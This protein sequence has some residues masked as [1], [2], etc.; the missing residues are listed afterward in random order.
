MREPI[1][2]VL[3][4]VVILGCEPRASP[5]A[6]PPG[7]ASSES[8]PVP[9]PPPAP[10]AGRPLSREEIVGAWNLT[11]TANYSSCPHMAVGDVRAVQWTI[12]FSLGAFRAR[13]LGGDDMDEHVGTVTA[14][15][16]ILFRQGSA[17]GVELRF[18]DDRKIVGRR[19]VANG[20]EVPCAIV[21]D[22]VGTSAGRTG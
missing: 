7:P 3:L 6:G 14:P 15:D 4:V 18:R 22:V 12:G 13:E 21:Y 17:V 19:V 8:K 16:R 5:Q 10:E 2:C 9:A 11:M 20:G 1:R